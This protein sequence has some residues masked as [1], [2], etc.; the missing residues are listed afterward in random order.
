MLFD[1]RAQLSHWQG[2]P[3]KDYAV[4]LRAMRANGRAGIVLPEARLSTGN[5]NTRFEILNRAGDVVVVMRCANT[6]AIPTIEQ[7]AAE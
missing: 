3:S 2:A 1:T 6:A 5:G 4:L 7:I